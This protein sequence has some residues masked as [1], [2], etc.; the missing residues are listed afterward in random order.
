M[1][2]VIAS[3]E[4]KIPVQQ[5]L[6]SSTVEG[7]CMIVNINLYGLTIDQAFFSHMYFSKV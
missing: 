3:L 5:F 1:I 7:M 4:G 6:S 2:Q